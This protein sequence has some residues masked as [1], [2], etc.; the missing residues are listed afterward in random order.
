EFGW[1]SGTAVMPDA[2]PDNLPPV[3]NVGPGSPTGTVFGYGARFPAKYQEAL[4]LCDW[5][6][7]KLY[8]LHLRPHG[9]TYTGELEEFLTGSPLPL[10]DIVVGPADGALYFT[11]GGRNTLSG[12]YRVSYIGQEST[13]PSKGDSTGGDQGAARRK[14]EGF[15]GKR[16]PRAVAT[17]WPYLSSEDAFL[18]YAARTALEFQDPGTWQEKALAEA[19]PAAL[20]HALVG[21]AR[22]GDK[23]LQPRLLEGLERVDWA[24][25][26]AA[27]KIDYLRT[28][29]LVFIRMGMPDVTWKERAGRRLDALYPAGTRE[30]NAEL[31][32]LI[33]F[34]E[35]PGG[36]T[37]TLALMAKAPTQE[38]QIEYAL[39]LRVV[40]SGWVLKEREAYFNWFHK[41]A[42]YR[43]GH[44]FHG[45]LRN[46]R[47]DAIETLSPQEQGD[48][49]AV[50][51]VTPRPTE[52]KF[53][54]RE[55]PFV[56]K[57]TVDELVPAVE[58]G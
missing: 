23:A 41:A 55:R 36:V 8:A 21:L 29:Q 39:A 32:K 47:A 20:T 49:K 6:Y 48:L 7:G 3:V 54:A 16:A 9:S 34:L 26:T 43:G 27:Q 38:E 35:V 33:S 53:A 50:L 11:T 58:K 42:S 13:A 12:L 19:N 57:W 52:P 37:K 22:V 31:C 56:K 51:A 1:R 45:F 4:F 30:L 17:A 10:T 46:I 44:S 5:S 24:K 18:R 25:L 40:K 14:L 15:Y 2:Y 28:Y